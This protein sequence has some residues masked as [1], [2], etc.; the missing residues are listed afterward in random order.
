MRGEAMAVNESK[1]NK[2]KTTVRVELNNRLP[3]EVVDAIRQR[4]NELG[5]SVNAWICI[6]VDEK[7]S[8][9]EDNFRR[10]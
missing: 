8:K 5:I 7:L 4:A 10:V 2:P 3:V 6:A 9:R 1:P